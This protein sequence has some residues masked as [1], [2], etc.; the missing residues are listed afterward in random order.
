MAT[1]TAHIHLKERTRSSSLVLGATLDRAKDF[2]RARIHTFI[3]RALRLALPMLALAMCGYYALALRL[4]TGWGGLTLP[5][6]PTFSS[7]NLAMEN[8]RYEG[9][10]KDGGRF[11][12]TAKTAKQDLRDRNAPVQLTGIDGNFLQPDQT[13]TNLKAKLGSFDNKQNQLELY[14]GIEVVS[15]NGMRATLTRATV[16]TKEHKIISREPVMVQMPTGTVSGRQMQLDQ[17]TKQIAFTDGVAARVTPE[18]KSPAPASG[19][20]PRGFGSSDAPVDITAQ[21]LDVDDTSKLAVFKGSVRAVQGD[22]VLESEQLEISYEGGAAGTGAKPQPGTDPSAASK[23]KRIVSPSSVVLT[24]GT[25]R[26]TGD[27]IEFDAVADTARVA[28]HVVMTSGTDRRA[29]SDRADMDQKSDTILLTGNVNVVQGKNELKGRRLWVDRKSGRAQLTG[30][31]EAGAT[32][33]RIS[34]RLYQ[35]DGKQATGAKRG[36]TSTQSAEPTLPGLGLASFK[37]DPN[38]PIDIEAGTLDINDTAKTAVY[39]IDVRVVQGDFKMATAEMTAFYDGQMGLNMAPGQSRDAAP[40]S[41]AQLNKIEARK[42]V[43][44]TSKDGQTAN[45]DWADFDTKANTVLSAATSS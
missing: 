10:S 15:Q 3:V 31:T 33:G 9:F 2:G 11:L 22:S 36:T 6:P 29:Q 8:P 37:T 40:K 21:R 1:S 14:D 42:G 35:S 19:A 4:A 45:G 24:Q 30:S 43:V 13:V 26:V 38:A 32:S 28:G 27:S 44:V 25:D 12:V 5:S 41:Q 39:R 17:K 18:R 16:L 34:T 7:E 23:L 20:A